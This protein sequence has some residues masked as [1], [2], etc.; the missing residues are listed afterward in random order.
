MSTKRKKH[1]H[2]Q[3]LWIIA[4]GTIL[5]CYRCGAW[6]MNRRDRYPWHR[7]TGLDGKNPAMNPNWTEAP[8][9]RDR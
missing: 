5:W 4:D 1:D 9:H 2:R 6:R 8:G 3:S 7:P